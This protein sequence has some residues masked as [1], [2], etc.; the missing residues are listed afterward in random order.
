MFGGEAMTK[1]KMRNDYEKNICGSAIKD[2]RVKMGLTQAQLG[3]RMEVRGVLWDQKTVSCVELKTRAIYD[4]ELK[5]LAE[6]LETTVDE[7]IN[8]ED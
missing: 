5:V 2:M 6:A 4:Y 3:A 7:L 8:A 1:R